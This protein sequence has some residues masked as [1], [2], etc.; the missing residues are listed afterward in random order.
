MLVI[1]KMAD[2]LLKGTLKETPLPSEHG[3]NTG[4]SSK[5]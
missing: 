4:E 5:Q 3:S 1:Y 2:K